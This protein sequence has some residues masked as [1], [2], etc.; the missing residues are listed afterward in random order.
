MINR[1][2]NRTLNI[3]LPSVYV[4]CAASSLA[5]G[6]DPHRFSKKKKNLR[7]GADQK[8]LASE[9]DCAVENKFSEHI[10]SFSFHI[11]YFLSP[12]GSFA[13]VS[14]EYYIFAIIMDPFSALYLKHSLLLLKFMEMTECFQ[15]F[16]YYRIIISNY[17][18]K[19]N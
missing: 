2:I 4:H 8:P 9:D 10:N 19:V 14:E 6:F 13:E 16:R 18:N 1:K 11:M 12:F 7:S 15:N 5:K 3:F 17:S